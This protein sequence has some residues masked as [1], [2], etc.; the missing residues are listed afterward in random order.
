M[1]LKVQ[2]RTILGKKTKSL[3]QGGFIPAELF[4]HGIANK[5][6]SVVAKD[7]SKVY[8]EAGE[9]TVITL[10]DEKGGKF[11]ALITEVAQDRLSNSIL[12]ID[13]HHI[14]KGE[15]IQTNVPIEF[16]GE[17]PAIKKGLLLVKVIDEIEVEALPE[18]IPHRFEVD[19]SKLADAG[20]SIAIHD[21]TIGKEV[22]LITS[23]DTIIATITEPAKE[24]EVQAAAPETAG[25]ET[26]QD[27]KQEA[28]GGDSKD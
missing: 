28:K 17:A 10:I 4:G 26:A 5:H 15:K 23:P 2:E 24:E 12:A 7:F 16:L 25:T 9:N 22:K 19:L 14:K 11:P 6:L 8:K 18:H 27:S 21:L 3:R 1:E 13:F 20:Q